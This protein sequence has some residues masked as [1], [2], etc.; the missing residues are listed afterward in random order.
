MS[1]TRRTASSLPK[2]LLVATAA[3]SA[4]LWAASAWS[5]DGAAVDRRIESAI[6]ELA[7]SD[8]SLAESDFEEANGAAPDEVTVAGPEF[9][10]A[11]REYRRA[12]TLRKDP[13]ETGAAKSFRNITGVDVMAATDVGVADLVGHASL[14]VSQSALDA[15]AARATDVKRGSGAAVSAGAGSPE[16]SAPDASEKSED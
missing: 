14:V 11:W 13:E 16:D 15:L 5:W 6:A 2:A 12:L 1:P 10:A 7:T 4:L 3:V 8:V 9:A